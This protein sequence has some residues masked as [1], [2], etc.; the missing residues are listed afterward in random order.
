[1][2]G[3]CMPIE[4]GSQ[5]PLKREIVGRS[6]GMRGNERGDQRTDGLHVLPAVLVDVDNHMD[7]GGGPQSADDAPLTNSQNHQSRRIEGVSS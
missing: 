7:R 2:L 4:D 1:M 5:Q 6:Q 3:L